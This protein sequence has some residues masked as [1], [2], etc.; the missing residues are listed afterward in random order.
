MK[1]IAKQ[2]LRR[3]CYCGYYGLCLIAEPRKWACAACYY[4]KALK[5][6]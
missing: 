6:H 1:K 3:C 4:P 5:K 2:L